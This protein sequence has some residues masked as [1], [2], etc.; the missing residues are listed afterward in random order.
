MTLQELFS[1]ANAGAGITWLGLMFAPLR[2]DAPRKAGIV[3]AIAL[4]LVYA[5]LI[6]AFIT[7][8]KGGFDSLANVGK[9]FEHPGLLLAG[10]VHYLAFDLLIGVWQREQARALGFS[11]WLL[12]PVLFLTFMLGP[13][14]W[15]AFLAV[16]Q[17]RSRPAAAAAP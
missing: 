10:W 5:A 17:V 12:A 11:L 13:A 9:L 1:I 15:L 2:F 6:A 14:G 8:G 16:R 7:Q 4:A 3:V